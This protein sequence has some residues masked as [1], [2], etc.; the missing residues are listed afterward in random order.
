MFFQDEKKL[1]SEKQKN[2]KIVQNTSIKTNGKFV[3]QKS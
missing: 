2:K 1:C 3:K